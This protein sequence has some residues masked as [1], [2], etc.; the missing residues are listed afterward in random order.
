LYLTT[1]WLKSDN[2]SRGVANRQAEFDVEKVGW[3]SRHPVLNDVEFLTRQQKFPGIGRMGPKSNGKL[4]TRGQ[5]IGVGL[6]L[7]VAIGAAFN[8]VGIGLALG[9]CFGIALDY[10]RDFKNRT[11][12][13]EAEE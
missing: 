2:V 13:D 8:A 10:G 3:P 9:V 4:R 1:K 5:G 6:A 12:E 11:D 7:G